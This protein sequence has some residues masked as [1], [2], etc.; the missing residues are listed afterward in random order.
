MKDKQREILKRLLNKGRISL[1]EYDL[2]MRRIE[3]PS[4]FEFYLKAAVVVLV[5]VLAVAMSVTLADW[6]SNLL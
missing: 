3:R 4:E 5:M 1:D 6:F 2:M